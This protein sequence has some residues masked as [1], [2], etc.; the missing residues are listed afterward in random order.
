MNAANKNTPRIHQPRRQ[1]VTASVVG[2]KKQSYTLASFQKKMVK[3]R[4]IAGNAEEE[5]RAAIFAEKLG[6]AGQLKQKV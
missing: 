2:L 1:N 5:A 4:D 6:M 3:P